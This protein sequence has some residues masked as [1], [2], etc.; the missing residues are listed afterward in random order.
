MY[1]KRLISSPFFACCSCS[2]SLQTLV[3]LFLA[4]N[5]RAEEGALEV[6]KAPRSG[7]PTLALIRFSGPK[8]V[9]KQLLRTIRVADWF[10]VRYAP[11][12]DY[13]LIAGYTDSDGEKQLDMRLNGPE[14]KP[15]QHFR[16]RI[17]NGTRH[18][19]VQRAV[20]SLIKRVHHRP[21]FCEAPLAFTKEIGGKKEV[22][23]ADFDGSNPRM[24]THNGALSVEPAWSDRGDFLAYTFYNRHQ[25]QV[26]LAD[27]QKKRQRV[28]TRFPGLNAAPAFSHSGKKMALILS[29]DGKVDLYVLN[30][31]NSK[32][33]RLTCTDGVEGSPAW[34]PNDRRIC[35]V[36]NDDSIRPTLKIVD[37]KSKRA[38][39]LLSSTAEC[40]SPDWSAQSN[41]LCFALRRN[42]R[43]VIAM[44]DM[45]QRQPAPKILVRAPGQWESPAWTPDGRHLVCSRTIGGGQG[46]YLLD[47]WY[48]KIT[49][50]RHYT[51]RDS[52]PAFPARAGAAP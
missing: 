33:T 28:L 23:L 27:L 17:R 14:G 29:R 20:D 34:S 30:L 44:A 21:G 22:W 45:S 47:S 11:P 36:S 19:L 3:L 40:V 25:T 38:R 5:L 31:K 1:W 7:N 15:L 26:V 32:T 13:Q 16:I 51:G 49:P 12:S 48:G 39:R 37:V 10:D 2:S 18:L 24:L 9:R 52:L 8:D 43:Y 6:V 50:L 41:L 42:G 35:Y 46:L 4:V